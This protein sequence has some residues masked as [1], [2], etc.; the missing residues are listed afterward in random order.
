MG[1][2]LINEFCGHEIS[3]SVPPSV[4]DTFV[5][6]VA[7]ECDHGMNDWTP[8]ETI[9]NGATEQVPLGLVMASIAADLLTERSR[10]ID[11]LPHVFAYYLATNFNC[12]VVDGEMVVDGEAGNM[13]GLTIMGQ[14]KLVLGWNPCPDT[15][16]HFHNNMSLHE[17]LATELMDL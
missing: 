10:G 1:T 7:P 14:D 11:G 4:K 6:A 9:T 8:V 5:I 3:E 13:I 16:G 12:R 2:V 15:P 17:L